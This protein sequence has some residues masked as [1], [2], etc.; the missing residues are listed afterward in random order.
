MESTLLDAI[1][2]EEVMTKHWDYTL[3]FKEEAD[4]P[5]IDL[6]DYVNLSEEKEDKTPQNSPYYKFCK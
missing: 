6:L 4:E 5:Y 2:R 1:Q 3:M